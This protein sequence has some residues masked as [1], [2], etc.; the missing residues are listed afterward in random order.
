MKTLRARLWL[1]F[2]GLLLLLIIVAVSSLS[3]VVLT[4][5][6]RAL[7]QVLRENYD[8]AGFCD[9]MKD[10][11]DRLDV[12][13]QREVWGAIDAAPDIVA[14]RQQFDDNLA[15][16]L[17]NCTLPGERKRTEELHS[18][19]FQYQ[20]LAEKGVTLRVDVPPDLPDVLADPASIGYALTNLLTNALKFTPPGGEVR[21]VVEADS[22]RR[23]TRERTRHH[24][25]G[26][27]A[28]HGRARVPP[29]RASFERASARQEPRPP[30]AILRTPA[31]S[32]YIGKSFVV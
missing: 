10:A 27:S 13:A 24:F 17:G 2:G 9:R 11:L 4:R 1:G 26:L 8:S 12:A 30:H 31:Y 28:R 15:R 20:G 18:E 7:Q 23:P 14:G 6:S 25:I 16:Q 5:Y 3:V 19:W 21:V 22:R 32:L 29:S